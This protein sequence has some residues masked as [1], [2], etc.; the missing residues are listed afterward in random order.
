LNP[1]V[2]PSLTNSEKVLI[3][4]IQLIYIE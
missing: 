2:L 1:E 4:Y 3:A